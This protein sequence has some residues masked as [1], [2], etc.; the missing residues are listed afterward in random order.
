MVLC[1]FLMTIVSVPQ[2]WSDFY[3]TSALTA[4]A[5]G[6]IQQNIFFFPRVFCPLFTTWP[7]NIKNKNK[8]GE[9]EKK[10]KPSNQW[11]SYCSG[12]VSSQVFKKNNNNPTHNLAIA[13]SLCEPKPLHFSVLAANEGCWPSSAP[14]RCDATE[15]GLASCTFCQPPSPRPPPSTLPAWSGWCFSGIPS[16]GWC[17]Y[18]SLYVIFLLS[19]GCFLLRSSSITPFFS[20]IRLVIIIF[21]Y[22]FFPPP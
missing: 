17:L 18:F 8:G 2:L 1:C 9:G 20:P 10:K 15:N 7:K 21:F 14:H 22:F 3:S 11:C 4:A 12:G 5:M 19:V 13:A 6:L 16:R